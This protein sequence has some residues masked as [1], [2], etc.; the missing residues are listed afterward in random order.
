[1]TARRSVA[2][3]T[4]KRGPLESHRAG[5]TAQAQHA[6]IGQHDVAA[7]R[8][9]ATPAEDPHADVLAAEEKRSQGVRERIGL[10]D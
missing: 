3:V 9:S 4:V 6:P 7:L 5:V 8:G 10:S 1:M 2:P